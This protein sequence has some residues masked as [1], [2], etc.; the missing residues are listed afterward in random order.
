M[1]LQLNVSNSLKDLA[2][3]LAMDLRKHAG[4]VFQTRWLVTQTDGM[5]N[6]LTIQLAGKVGINANCRF[7]KPN[8]IVNQIYYW[9]GG[10]DKQVLAADHLKWLIYNLLNEEEFIQ[11]FATIS[12]YYL[13]DDV[14][15]IAL[16]GRV[17][18][19]FDQYQ[20]YRPEMVDEWNSSATK[21]TTGNDWQ[22]YL[23]VKVK[24]KTSPALTDKTSVIRYIINELNDPAQQEK[25]YARLPQVHIFGVSIITHLHI[26]LFNELSKYISVSFY[27]L[28]PAPLVYWLD[29][30]T[31]KQIARLARLQKTPGKLSDRL[32]GAGNT[33]LIS[34]GKVIQETFGLLF[35]NDD[36]LNVYNDSGV[37]EPESSPGDTMLQKI[38][39]DI[40]YNHDSESRNK[41]TINDL[42]DGSLTIHACYTQVREVES[43]YNYLVH[44]A[45]EKKELLSPREIVVMVSDIDAYA[46]YIKAIFNTAIYRFPFSIADESYQSGDSLFTAIES[47]LSISEDD[48]T[49]EDVMEL[50]DSRYIRSRFNITDTAL[51][52]KVV[53]AANIRF[54]IEGNVDDDTVLVSWNNGLQRILYGICMSGSTEY[55]NE[56][57]SIYPLDM[58]EGEDALELISFSHF[59]EV[60]KWYVKDRANKRNLAEW[61]QYIQDLA[62]NLVYQP[63]TND[64][65]EDYQRL[66]L[67]IENLNLLTDTYNEAI[68][69]EVFKHSFLDI[70]ATQT[71]S[72]S[73]AVGG[74]TFC[75]LIPMRSIPFKVV[76][77]LGMDFD[78]F[79]RREIPLSFN[80]METKRR[81][82]DRNVKDN[83]KHLFLETVLSAKEYLYISFIGRNAKDNS[84]HPPSALVDELVDYVE[85][86]LTG[87]TIKVRDTLIITQ[88]LH[89]FS[90]KYFKHLPGLYSYLGDDASAQQPGLKITGKTKDSKAFEWDEISATAL[91]AFY[92]N[93]FKWYYN[94]VLGIYYNDEEVLLPDTELFELDKLQEWRLKQDILYL[95][96]VEIPVYQ[97]KALKT[98]ALPLKHMADIQIAKTQEEVS[99]VKKMLQGCI[100]EHVER[101][102]LIEISLGNTVVAGKLTGIY[103]DMII[104]VSFSKNHYKYLLEAYIRYV[105][106]TAQGLELEFKYLSAYENTVFTIPKNTLSK[107]GAI[108]VLTQL[109]A[110][111]KI[112]HAEIFLLYPGLN[113]N[114]LKI[115]DYD[116]VKFNSQVSKFLERNPDEYLKK[117]FDNGIFSTAAVVRQFLENTMSVFSPVAQLF[118]GLIPAPKT[119]KS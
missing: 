114:P 89:G 2:Q 93:P 48:F 15:R 47:I 17:A 90:Q 100:G 22:K 86:G 12:A 77:L 61:G 41:L 63:D 73:F 58:A 36:F 44:L 74:I 53:N 43:L 62:D 50:L 29:D 97:S 28:N 113:E 13:G 92:K 52:R 4:N 70:I 75:S 5:N 30:R 94:K 10:F 11:Q 34:W 1:S 39:Q 117:E 9:L 59:I 103:G 49:A 33:L 3:Q 64:P 23:W 69:F 67:Y 81:K 8:D 42:Q 66:L 37:E 55:N 109:I 79:P 98:G 24:E 6:W 91:L 83:D 72:G 95:D 68:S 20:V 96:E 108:E 32:A 80:L 71:R 19:L 26:Q 85:S 27:L 102:E 46:P 112:G 14:K 119:S 31:E 54:G 84:V 115:V 78:K 25:I 101:Q 40:F 60:L 104:A 56:G 76:A 116:W 106:V 110:W 87:T 35:E 82:G 105:L 45:D 111:F 51:V 57:N 21:N 99:P 118:P 18:D 65:D 107:T 7:V 16:A 88:P 38:Q